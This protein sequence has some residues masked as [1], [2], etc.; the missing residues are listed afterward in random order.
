[1]EYVGVASIECTYSSPS[2]SLRVRVVVNEKSIVVDGCGGCGGC[3]D[4]SDC[5]GDKNSDVIVAVVVIVMMT[6]TV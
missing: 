3:G 6:R 4:V 2:S 5:V 1:M